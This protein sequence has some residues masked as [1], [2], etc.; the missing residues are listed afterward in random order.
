MVINI[1]ANTPKWCTNSHGSK[2]I[3]NQRQTRTPNKVRKTNSLIV[4]KEK[5]NILDNY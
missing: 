5:V 2:Y 4:N 3:L 1:V